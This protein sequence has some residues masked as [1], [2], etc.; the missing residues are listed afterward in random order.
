MAEI[1]DFTP[2]ANDNGSMRFEIKFNKTGAGNK[3]GKILQPHFRKLY[4][5]DI[6][7]V[8]AGMKLTVLLSKNITQNSKDIEKE[9]YSAAKYV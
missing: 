1:T 6:S 2:F 8:P 4:G 3:V 5:T 7:V 9:I